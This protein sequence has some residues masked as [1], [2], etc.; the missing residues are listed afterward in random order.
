MILQQTTQ[1]QKSFQ[2]MQARNEVPSIFLLIVNM[3]MFQVESNI[4]VTTLRTSQKHE[5]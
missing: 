5:A 3:I 2:A 4:N 1:V